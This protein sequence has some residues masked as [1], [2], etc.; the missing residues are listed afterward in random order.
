MGRA[1]NTWENLERRVTFFSGYLKERYRSGDV[2]KDARIIL[3]YIF[4][5]ERGSVDRTWL[6]EDKIRWRAFANAKTNL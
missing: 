1:R 5:K 3:K 6:A 4:Y 2:G